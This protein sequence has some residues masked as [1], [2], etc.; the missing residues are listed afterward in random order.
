MKKF[1][2]DLINWKNPKYYD[3]IHEDAPDEVCAWEFLR[4][5]P[6]YQRDFYEYNRTGKFLGYTRYILNDDGQYIPRHEE[7]RDW[8]GLSYDSKNYDPRKRKCPTFATGKY[9]F[10]AQSDNNALQATSAGQD[11]DNLNLK[12]DEVAV[13]LS[14]SHNLEDQIALIKD[15]LKQQYQQR[16]I[17]FRKRKEH[18]SRYLRLL[19]AESLDASEKEILAILFSDQERGRVIIHA[20]LK[21][22][23]MLRDYTY[24]K[25]L[26]I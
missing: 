23:K 6:Q 22:A 18:Y 7:V 11:I 8:Y 15:R 25:L 2:W 12:Q 14:I 5:N 13:V 16:I 26:A 24:K 20:N 1:V 9:P 21:A 10:C 17:T 4:R 19:D 3:H